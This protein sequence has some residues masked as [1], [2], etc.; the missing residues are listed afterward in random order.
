MPLSRDLMLRALRILANANVPACDLRAASKLLTEAAD[1]RELEA[2]R[3]PITNED[4]AQF[5]E[6]AVRA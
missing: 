1:W 5:A 2:A 3:V 4:R 6:T